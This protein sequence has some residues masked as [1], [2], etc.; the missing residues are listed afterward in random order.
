LKVKSSID[1]SSV[2]GNFVKKSSVRRR[3]LNQVDGCEDDEPCE[4]EGKGFDW[5]VSNHD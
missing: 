4:A 5:H 1:G 2:L 3:V